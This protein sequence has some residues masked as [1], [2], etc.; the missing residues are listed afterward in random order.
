MKRT[1][2]KSR[3]TSPRDI[4][5]GQLLLGTY[6]VVVVVV[7]VMRDV[8]GA[9]F[10][11]KLAS[12]PITILHGAW[13]QLFSSGLVVDG[14][15]LPQIAAI[16]VLGAVGLYFRGSLLFW[17]TAA[18]GHLFGTIITYI[19][20]GIAWLIHPSW[21]TNLLNQQDY[22]ISLVWC[23]A[24]G[25]VAAAAWR[26]PHSR[27]FRPYRPVVLLGA[28]AI[29]GVVTWY[30]I[31]LASYEHISAFVI[32]FLIV[33][34]TSQHRHVSEHMERRDRELGRKFQHA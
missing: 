19:G 25:I 29:I 12:T 22:G 33:A 21:V 20:V 32:A 31:G 5:F 11:A 6:I 2:T 14:P 27:R 23:A 30:S 17:L 16:G 13:W 10:L 4:S 15:L 18:A 34:L 28:L 7:T 8:L 26:G 24:L 9:P 1:S 3:R